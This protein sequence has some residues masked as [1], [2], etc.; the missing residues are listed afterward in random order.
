MEKRAEEENKRR[1]E[2]EKEAMEDSIV[3]PFLKDK[4]E[5]GLFVKC[6]KESDV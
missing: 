3:K 1:Q 5:D 2:K 6:G 4:I